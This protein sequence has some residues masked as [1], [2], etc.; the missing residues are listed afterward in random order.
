[1]L[2]LRKCCMLCSILSFCLCI[3]LVE[4]ASLIIAIFYSVIGFEPQQSTEDIHSSLIA[5][6][7]V[8][9]VQFVLGLIFLCLAIVCCCITCAIWND[10]Y[11]ARENLNWSGSHESYRDRSLAESS[12]DIDRWGGLRASLPG[13]TPFPDDRRNSFFRD[14][15]PTYSQLTNI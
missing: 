12:G 1:M 4:I 10:T 11:E 2:N 6:L 8:F 5:V 3:F 13:Y 15:P 7:S 14:N 9:F